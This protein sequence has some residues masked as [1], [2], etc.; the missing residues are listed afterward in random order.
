MRNFPGFSNKFS[1]L[2]M[3]IWFYDHSPSNK[4][5]SNSFCIVSAQNMLWLIERIYY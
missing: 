2:G 5:I 1:L 3:A 4:G